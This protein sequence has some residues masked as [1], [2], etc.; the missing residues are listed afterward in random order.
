LALGL[1]LVVGRQND[2]LPL[3]RLML[4]TFNEEAFGCL[5]KWNFLVERNP[6]H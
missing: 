3:L 2:I 1:R 5:P 6:D 4:F